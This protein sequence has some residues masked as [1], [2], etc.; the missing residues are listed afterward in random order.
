VWGLLP[1]RKTR[2]GAYASELV[3]DARYVAQRPQTLSPLEAVVLPVAGGTALQI[4]DR[5]KPIAGE[6]MLVHGA[7]GGVGH[8]LVQVAHRRGVQVAAA[9]SSSHVPFLAT[10]GVRVIVDRH[11]DDPWRDLHDRIDCPLGL[12]ADLVGGGLVARSIPLTAEGRRIAAIVDL[13]GDFE[14]AV[15][16]NSTLHGILLQPGRTIL[17]RLRVLVEQGAL[18]PK[19][20]KVYGMADAARAH[21][22]ITTGSTEGKLVLS[23]GSK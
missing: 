9:T 14:E 19:I 17:D 23:M 11:G 10:L 1:V 5:L 21:T 4:I 18:Q 6:W 20:D 22:R 13:V 3:T 8:M 12:V 16:R 7:A 15:D 2:W